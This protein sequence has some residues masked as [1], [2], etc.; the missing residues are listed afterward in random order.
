MLRSRLDPSSTIAMSAP[1]KFTP[2]IRWLIAA[3]TAFLTFAPA[4]AA[5][6]IYKCRNA[7][8]GNSYL[9]TPCPND[10]KTV[11]VRKY[12]PVADSRNNVRPMRRQ[13]FLVNP[14]QDYVPTSAPTPSVITDEELASTRN[15]RDL[16]TVLSERHRKPKPK[17]PTTVTDQ[18]GRRYS[19]PPGSAFV[20]EES[21]GKMCFTYGDFIQ[22]D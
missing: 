10:A 9:Q 13:N 21:T 16:A 14:R 8:G 4:L 15:S 22:C 19:Q 2:R 3:G 17:H 5:Q 18:Y 1:Q 7:D 11:N 20:T 6:Q 12:S